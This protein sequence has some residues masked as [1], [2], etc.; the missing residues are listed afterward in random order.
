MLMMGNTKEKL[1]RGKL[2]GGNLTLVTATLGTPYEI[3][4]TDSFFFFED[5]LENSYSIDRMLTHLWLANKFKDCKGF[6]VGKIKGFEK[7]GN[8]YPNKAFTIKE[9]IEE[10]ANRLDIPC[11]YNIPFGHQSS[12]IIFPCGAEAEVDF[13]KKEIILN[14]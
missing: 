8:F 6:I 1:I 2:Q 14:F 3:D 13:T 10:Y 7:R 5:T 4:L 9:I 12:E 11:F